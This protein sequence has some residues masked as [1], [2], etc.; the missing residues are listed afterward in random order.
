VI[1]SL[2]VLS[3]IF[4]GGSSLHAQTDVTHS[5]LD[6][7][8]E[9]RDAY[10]S[11][12]F[13]AYQSNGKIIADSIPK[14]PSFQE[15][16]IY[17][18]VLRAFNLEDNPEWTEIS[19]GMRKLVGYQ[20]SDHK[21]APVSEWMRTMPKMIQAE[22]YDL[23]L[24]M[25]GEVSMTLLVKEDDNRIEACAYLMLSGNTL[26]VVDYVGYIDPM[27]LMKFAQ[28]P[29]KSFLD[30]LPADLKNFLPQQ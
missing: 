10:H 19:R 23:W 20:V 28:D 7:L 14:P 25:S 2:F 29:E 13:E 4:L 11:A 24:E 9:L 15:V 27:T 22:G 6:Q 18:S 12:R 26:T 17:P 5:T 21:N 16:F 30:S 1:R 3:L 8:N